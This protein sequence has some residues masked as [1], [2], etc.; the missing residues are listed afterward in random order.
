MSQEDKSVSNYFTFLK[1][2][3]DELLIYRPLSV[4]L[5]GK[6]SCGVL[7]TLTE[8]HHQEYVLQFLMGLNESFSHVK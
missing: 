3:W 5:C 4:C 8:Y 6:C 7:K 2:L 1:G